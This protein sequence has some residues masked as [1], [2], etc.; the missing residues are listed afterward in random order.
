MI[1]ASVPA[2]P[3]KRND[4]YVESMPKSK[5]LAGSKIVV[6]KEVPLGLLSGLPAFDQIAISSQKGRGIGSQRSRLLEPLRR[7]VRDEPPF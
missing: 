7:I 3:L 5:R 1:R 6:L 2:V 4:V